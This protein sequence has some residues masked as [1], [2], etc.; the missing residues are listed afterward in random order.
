MRPTHQHR[1]GRTVPIAPEF[2]QFY[3]GPGWRKTREEVRTRANDKCEHCQR[4]NG[5]FGIQ[6]GAAH[7]NHVPG[8][9]RP[10]NL[11]WLCRACHLRYDA[12]KHKESRSARKD[13][14][15]PLLR[16]VADAIHD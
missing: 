15:R 3:R 2:K 5:I 14:A 1:L 12:G 8:D 7:L 13:R 16:E 4:P 11:A 10:E 6:C 9:D